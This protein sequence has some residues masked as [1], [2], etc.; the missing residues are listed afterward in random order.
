MEWRCSAWHSG[1]DKAICLVIPLPHS[2]DCT[3]HVI[4]TLRGR[5]MPNHTI[6]LTATVSRETRYL[7]KRIPAIDSQGEAE[8]RRPTPLLDARDFEREMVRCVFS[9]ED[10]QSRIR[11]H[12]RTMRNRSR[13]WL[14]SPSGSKTIDRD[15]GKAPRILST[16]KAVENHVTG[17]GRN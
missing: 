17:H 7:F 10:G 12:S 8:V 6:W 16:P 5:L 1:I 3:S 11:R 2:K 13:L 14:M 4:G 15:G 9:G